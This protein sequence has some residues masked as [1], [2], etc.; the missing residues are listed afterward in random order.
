MLVIKDGCVHNGRGKVERVDI[1][2]DGGKIVQI[3][4]N[5]LSADADIIN[6]AGLDVFP[7]FVDAQNAWGIIGPG[8]SGD[9]RSEDYDP[10]T[11]EMNVVYAF[12]QDG[13]NFQR[14]YT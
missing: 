13:M 4:S 2:I 11:P 9:D 10:L 1:A 8:W 5:I 14:V 7:G 3:G 12:D 6:A